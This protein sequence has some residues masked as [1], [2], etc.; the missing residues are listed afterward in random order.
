M[1]KPNSDILQTLI[2][3]A[4]KGTL[5]GCFADV[6]VEVYHH[7]QCPGI[8]STQLK[9]IIKKSYAH[10]CNEKR[11]ESP[12]LKFGSAFH[13]FVNEPEEFSNTYQIIYGEKTE[14][15]QSGRIALSIDDFETIKVMQK[16]VFEHPDAGP[17]I[18][19]AQFELTYWS[20]DQQTGI[21]KKCRVD[22]I[23]N[24]IISDLKSCADA[25]AETF[26]RDARKYLYRISGAYYLEI[27][28]EVLGEH[29]ETFNLI[30]CEKQQP[31]E[32]NVFRISDNSLRKANE[33]IRHALKIIQTI[34]EQGAKAWS[35]Y[36]LG[37]KDLHI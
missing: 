11:T 16:K 29:L 25:S 34:H 36:D 21:L 31:H 28:S 4:D 12:A 35:G 30:A 26:A 15:L 7:S 22:A 37:I 1:D 13:C 5:T 24:K 8:S 23:K 32:I 10:F 20:V 33:E 2:S 27:V 18:F 14:R 17:L 6:P 9:G 19:D 3:M